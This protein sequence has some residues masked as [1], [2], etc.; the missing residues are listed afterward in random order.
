MSVSAWLAVVLALVSAVSVS[1][2]AAAA[3]TVALWSLDE[4]AGATTA[5]AGG[6]NRLDGTVGADVETG[7]PHGGATGY[8]FAD[9]EPNSPPVRPGHL[10]LVPHSAMLNPDDGDFTVTVRFRTTRGPGNVVQKG[11]NGSPGGY[12]KV[13]HE[14]GRARCAFVGPDGEGG[15]IAADV[16]VDDGR[17]HT[18][19]CERTADGVTVSVDGEGRRTRTGP[20]GTISNTAELMIGGKAQC[21]QQQVGCD[22]FSG[23][24]DYVRVLKGWARGA[25]HW[26][27]CCLL[28]RQSA[29]GA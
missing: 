10:V 23:D 8:R 1:V 28:E 7:V 21:D 20:T 25:G 18:V 24:I 19:T 5:S 16:R 26:S 22:Y 4:P 27:S 29:G 3:G 13:E 14:D 12:W 2:S 9:V 15:A 6:G 11:Q 17:W